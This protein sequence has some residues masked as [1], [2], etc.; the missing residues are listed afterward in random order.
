MSKELEI[1]NVVLGHFL[2]QWDDS[3]TLDEIFSE[4]SDSTSVAWEPY[5]YWDKAYLKNHIKALI[6]NLVAIEGGK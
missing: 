3:S 2:T 5:E 6:K 1:Q 4:D